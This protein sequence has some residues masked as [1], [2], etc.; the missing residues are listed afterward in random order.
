MSQEQYICQDGVFLKVHYIPN[1]LMAI[2]KEFHA[3]H[4]Y[5]I[6][7]QGQEE[8]EATKGIIRIRI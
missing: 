7:R 3:K 5:I 4:N 8:F 6:H 1:T 2:E